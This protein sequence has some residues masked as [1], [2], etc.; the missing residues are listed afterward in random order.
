MI[1]VAIPGEGPLYSQRRFAGCRI[2]SGAGGQPRSR[3][4]RVETL[5]LLPSSAKA[6]P[7]LTIPFSAVVLCA[8]WPAC[9]IRPL[10]GDRE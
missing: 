4:R 8:W 5:S 1:G 6:G 2:L 3:R 10:D 9:P 7:R